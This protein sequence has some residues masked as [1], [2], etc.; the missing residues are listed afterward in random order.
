VTAR[1][2]DVKVDPIDVADA[3]AVVTPEYNHGYPGGVA[4]GLRSVEMLRLVFTELQAVT[5]RRAV[6]EDGALRD[7]GPSAAAVRWCSRP[8]AGRGASS[9]LIRIRIR[10]S[11]GVFWVRLRTPSRW[12]GGVDVA[13]ADLAG[14]G[15]SHR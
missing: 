1:Y 2:D 8:I 6:L 14:R 7:P 4:G 13:V 3:F 11:A 12:L 10:R 5:V 15:V 9:R